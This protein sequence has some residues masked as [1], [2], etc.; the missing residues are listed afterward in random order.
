[1]SIFSEQTTSSTLLA[2]ARIIVTRLFLSSVCVW[3]PFFW[4]KYGASTLSLSLGCWWILHY[5][6]SAVLSICISHKGKSQRDRGRNSRFRIGLCLQP[7]INQLKNNLNHSN[8][9]FRKASLNWSVS[10]KEKIIPSKSKA[11]LH[12]DVCAILV[13]TSTIHTEHRNVWQ[14][15]FCGSVFGCRIERYTTTINS[16]ETKLVYLYT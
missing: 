13:S 10:L 8:Y 15:H 11:T 1:M 4:V 12:T 5:R 16:A 3:V 7:T 9:E 14:T 2:Y 6:S